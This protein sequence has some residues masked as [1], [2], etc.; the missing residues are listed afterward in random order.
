MVNTPKRENN[1]KYT[2]NDQLSCKRNE[3][4]IMELKGK[5]DKFTIIV[6]NFNILSPVTVE[7]LENL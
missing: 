1:P 5:A 6:S 2:C 3:T 4:K 7:Q